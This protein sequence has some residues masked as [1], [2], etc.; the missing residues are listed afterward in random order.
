[1]PK[2]YRLILEVSGES[3]SVTS[4]FQI[5]KQVLKRSSD[6]VD[7]SDLYLGAAI[8]LRDQD[9]K[10]LAAYRVNELPAR[11]LEYPTH[12]PER[13]FGHVEVSHMPETLSILVPAED[14]TAFVALVANRRIDTTGTPKL[15]RG[16]ASDD[17]LATRGDVF[18]IAVNS[19][20]EVR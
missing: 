13:S 14:D 8:E 16:K 2:A 15:F 3:V 1:M 18:E 19:M 17:H 20:K 11:H 7:V 9:R 4:A 5:E 6:K 12:D 10:V